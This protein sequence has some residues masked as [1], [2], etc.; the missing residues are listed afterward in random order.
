MSF[1]IQELFTNPLV[2][3]M[4]LAAMAFGLVL[5]NVL[6]ALLA[7]SLG[8]DTAKNQ[9]Y[10]STE[11]RVHINPIYL[12]FLAIFGFAI[13]NP[14][15]VKSYNMR[16]RSSSEVLVWL[17]G[18]FSLVL[19]GFVL[20]LIGAIL[21]KFGGEGVSAIVSGFF[22]GAGNVINLAVLFIFPV[23][24]LDGARALH[25]VGNREINRVLDGLQNFT[26]STPFGFMI[27][28]LVLSALGVTGAISRVIISVIV[29]ILQAIG[30]S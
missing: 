15:P 26:N 21:G 14:I 9:G 5:H 29:A 18:P 17:M 4:S 20:I 23:P 25:A 12:I 2:Y 10:T 22:A 7:S 19:W 11:P 13:P 8:D 30:L 1:F 16:G 3:L 24:P 28:F 6:Q 27:I